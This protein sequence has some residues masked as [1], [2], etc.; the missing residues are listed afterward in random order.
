MPWPTL[1]KKH[2][3]KKIYWFKYPL[4]PKECPSPAV[5]FAS[6]GVGNCARG[7]RGVRA[8]V[9]EGAR[10][11]VALEVFA[12][13]VIA[14]RRAVVGHGAAAAGRVRVAVALALPA[15]LL[16]ELVGRAHAVVAPFRVFANRRGVAGVHPVARASVGALVGV[17]NGND[18]VI[19]RVGQSAC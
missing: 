8:A 9:V 16:G 10:V 14:V 3:R 4:V 18:D 17:V 7:T 5:A 2:G 12:T 6:K 15:A 1:F 19:A 11:R 13:S